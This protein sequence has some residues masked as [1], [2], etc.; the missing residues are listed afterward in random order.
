MKPDLNGQIF[1]P[2]IHMQI[3]LIG[4]YISTLYS[5]HGAHTAFISIILVHMEGITSE[6]VKQ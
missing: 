1:L 5:S 6:A 4:K 3:R 2:I